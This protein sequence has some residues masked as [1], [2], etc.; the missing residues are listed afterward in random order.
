[1]ST[2]VKI[3]DVALLGDQDP[4][5]LDCGLT[6]PQAGA[7]SVELGL[8]IKGWAVGSTSPV[9]AIELVCE[10][11]L[12]REVPLD[13]DGRA[14]EAGASDSAP[15]RFFGVLGALRLPPRFTL[16]LRARFA[17]GTAVP[18]AEISGQRESLAG[19]GRPDDLRA[20]F[21]STPTGRTG[22][23]WVVHLLGHHPAIVA[24][25]PHGVEPRAASY[26]LEV[27][28][29]LSEPGS[30]KRVLRTNLE[31]DHWWLGEWPEAARQP[32]RD[33][34]TR[35]FLGRDRTLALAR[36]AR[37]QIEDFYRGVADQQGKHQVELFVEKAPMGRVR[38]EV[39][40]DLLAD[41][42]EVTLFRDPRDTICSILSYTEKN[43]KAAL[44]SDQPDAGDEYL[45]T[46]ASSFRGLLE[47]SR[48]RPGESL[49]VRYED[50]ILD[51]EP[52]LSRILAHLDLDAGEEG[53]AEML[54]S[55]WES[56]EHL[57][58]H[59]TASGSI[60][61]SIGRWRH[62]ME[63]TLQLRSSSIFADVLE[64]LDYLDGDAG[65]VRATTRRPKQVSKASRGLLR[66]IDYRRWRHVY[67]AGA[68]P[69]LSEP[70]PNA[71]V[72][73]LGAI[74]VSQGAD[75][76]ALRARGDGLVATDQHEPTRP[77]A[78]PMG[79]LRWIAAPLGWS[80]DAGFGVRARTSAGR[81][82]R[83]ISRPWRGGSAADAEATLGYLHPE[84]GGGRRGLFSSVHPITGD[85]LLTTRPKEAHDLGYP[86]PIRLGF[87]ESAAPVT[88]DLVPKRGIV[89]WA[90]RFGTWRPPSRS[91]SQGAIF[92]PVKGSVPRDA[93]RVRGWAVLRAEPVARI[94]VRINGETVGRARLGLQ[95]PRVQDS[96][97]PEA[98]ISGFD[99]RVPPSAVPAGIRHARIEAV[100][101]GVRGTRLELSAPEEIEIADPATAVSEAGVRRVARA[102]Q[103]PAT[104]GDGNGRAPSGAPPDSVA[105]GPPVTRPVRTER[106]LRVV[107]FAHSLAH[108]GAQRT[109]FEQ[110]DR[111]TASENFT[112]AVVA[113]LRGPWAQRFEGIGVPVHFA[114]RFPVPTPAEYE[115][116]VAE[117][118][119]VLER[120]APDVVLANTIDSF[121]GADAATR[122]GLPVA[123]I[124]H[125]SYEFPVWWQ[126]G[127]PSAAEAHARERCLEALFSAAATIFPADA[128]RTL[129]EPYVRGER[130]LTAPC[131]VEFGQIDEFRSSA[132]PAAARRSLGLDP[133]RR[134][135]LALGIAEPRKGNA[136]L[137][138]AWAMVSPDHPD[139]SLHMVGARET[140]YCEAI[141]RYIEAAG[142]S[143]SC[144]FEPPTMD[145]LSWHAAADLFVLASDVESAPIA[146]AEAMAFGT[147]A[148]ATRV[149]GVPELISDG[150]DGILFEPNDVADLAAT[151][152]AVLRM[153][154]DHLRAM[155]SRGARRVR[156]H[157]DPERFAER[158]GE[159]LQSIVR[160]RD[161]TPL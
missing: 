122:L 142:I 118:S 78:G 124:I 120:E 46:V 79:R 121:A 3:E 111:L 69:A 10:G 36:H 16:V 84:P 113:S 54:S 114:G 133:D 39:L 53:I 125:E 149:F 22:T 70:D 82:R 98:V 75:L 83:L 47:E 50:L 101:T 153:D 74:R 140:P 134:V 19:A 65:P 60:K 28:A 143:D 107:A 123:W 139:A 112:A 85:Q 9:S 158:L 35:R 15:S 146:L 154:A 5:L 145:P 18:F 37:E 147:P 43:P 86:D 88:G 62:D 45:E 117:L 76:I 92:E 150:L 12:L 157:H 7:S 109:L 33:E 115:Q 71:P 38:S 96:A 55:A 80:A 156:E 1:L 87:I 127:H 73:E 61:D 105:A 81:A 77:R 30:Y 137:A 20:G 32:I 59:R 161:A 152:D 110:L 136:V 64:E 104:G 24:Y 99:L 89:P 103:T 106:A 72:T 21:I 159:V 131:G 97:N 41:T 126:M 6:S 52:T 42:K 132:D 44:V 102:G 34:W 57:S 26:W 148:V 17:N 135:L 56:A 116:C 63:P 108:G 23:T 40:S 100:V 29:A 2:A 58:G 13:I 91:A 138:R 27:L 49:V 31:R 95:R 155:G 48:A 119:G 68:V 67:A 160:E 144:A 130:S 51:P 141:S 25:P 8:E 94:E 93:V 14:V 4:G 129:Y 90:H 128:T 11:E 151:L 66:T